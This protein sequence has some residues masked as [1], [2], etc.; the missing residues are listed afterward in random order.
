M[1]TKAH[2]K[3]IKASFLEFSRFCR[4]NRY[5]IL[6]LFLFTCLV[7]GDKLSSI[8][9]GIDTEKIIYEEEKLYSSWLGI[10]R[11]SLILLKWLLGQLHYNPY[12]AGILTLCF[13]VA[14]ITLFLFLFSYV[15]GAS[16]VESG[17]RVRYFSSCAFGMLVIAHPV[18]TEQMYFSLQGA[19]VMLALIL[20]AVSLF[21]AFRWAMGCGW[22]WFFYGF[23]LLFPALGVYQAF[24]PLFLFGIIAV[25]CLYANP[26][27]KKR[28][29]RDEFFCILRLF[30]VFLAAFT[31]NQLLFLFF[32]S[33]SGYLTQQLSW[34][35][36]ELIPGILRIASHIRDVFGG[37]GIFYSGMFFWLSLGLFVFWMLL[38]FGR[39]KWGMGL[40]KLSLLFALYAS[41]FYLTVFMGERPVI[42]GQLVLPFVT[43]FMAYLWGLFA[44]K[45]A[46][47]KIPAFVLKWGLFLICFLAVWKE[48]DIT[49]RL[50]YTDA[51]RYQ[52][53]L[54]LAEHLKQDIARLTGTCDFKGTVVFI[55]Q[56]KANTNCAC[57]LGDVM[58]Q[59]LFAWD[60]YVE[61][62]NFYS[63]SRIIGFMSCVG[64]GYRA[65]NMEEAKAASKKAAA[66]SCY[67]AN[68]S[69]LYQN[70]MVI[71]KLS[72]AID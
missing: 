25:G 32:S 72:E 54:S 47:S 10:G 44:E 6:L 22:L 35:N 9:H 70:G 33:G 13:L 38:C 42:R 52:E 26:V 27:G 56:R 63:S 59:S 17:S 12:F 69:M 28:S 41:P 2:L 4:Q 64:A 68:D 23:L 58:G 8:N 66:L 21:C 49:C 46:F 31:V 34:R 11:Q 29:F 7:H 39:H 55:G 71:V 61:P 20:C 24:V 62:A 30:L 57:I 1:K 16:G 14:G 40:W 36:G 15:K 5:I 60:T 51:I 48:T 19:E 67:P 37:R 18:L 50:Y 45:P 43:G 65:P 3:Q 53:D